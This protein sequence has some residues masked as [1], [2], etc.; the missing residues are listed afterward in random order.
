MKR[1]TE[2]R[3]S[4]ALGL[5]LGGDDPYSA[6]VCEQSD[7]LD[8]K[9]TSSELRVR[10]TFWEQWEWPR[11]TSELVFEQCKLK[12]TFRTRRANGPATQPH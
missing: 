4:A 3:S 12:N 2:P 7:G 8:G 6:Y 10:E 9:I 1:F 5:G 11:M